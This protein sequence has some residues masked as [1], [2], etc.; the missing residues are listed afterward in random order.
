MLVSSIVLD[1]PIAVDAPFQVV[2]D[3]SL[4]IAGQYFLFLAFDRRDASFERLRSLIGGAYGQ[5]IEA[6]G[7][8]VDAD[9]PPGLPI[10]V[11]WALRS[12]TGAV[13][14]G[15]QSDVLGAHSWSSREIARLLYKGDLRAGH[16]EFTAAL[17]EGISELSG[18]RARLRLER[19]PKLQ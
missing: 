4:A 17:A 15:E 13:L 9:E 10:P 14:A 18:I 11:R 8:L 6:N 19:E 2:R 3:I 12:P 7:T 16:Y 5:K 1:E